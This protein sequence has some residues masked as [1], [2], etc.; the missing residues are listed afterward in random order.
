MTTTNDDQQ[1]LVDKLTL[2]HPG[3]SYPIR[4]GASFKSDAIGVGTHIHT[5][6][7]SFRPASTD[8]LQPA[9]MRVDAAETNAQLEFHNRRAD[10][11]ASV[12]LVGKHTSAASK[13][14][15]I[16][17]FDAAEQCFVLEKVASTTRDVKKA[18]AAFE[19][20]M[21]TRSRKRA[22]PTSSPTPTA[23]VQPLPPP[24]PPPPPPPQQQQQ[25]A[26][27]RL[28]ASSA[29]EVKLTVSSQINRFL[30]ANDAD[31]DDDAAAGSSS[32]SEVQWAL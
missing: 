10:A 11:P 18:P 2:P 22:N 31:D 24:P 7:Y 29:N 32:S 15:C 12:C 16:L 25:N 13:R 5:V 23:A 27:I 14:E 26:E 9:A 3:A 4:L 8:L 20:T 17:I 19:P 1:S 28:N 6:A 21:L 30:D